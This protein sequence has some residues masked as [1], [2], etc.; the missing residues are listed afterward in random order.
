MIWPVFATVSLLWIGAFA[1]LFLVRWSED[2]APVD[3]T[4]LLREQAC[5]ASYRDPEARDRCL[6]IMELE[7]FQTRSIMVA[8]RVLAGASL[9]LI[10]F[11]VL[12][13]LGRR[14]TGRKGRRT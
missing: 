10:G 3:R 14:R 2:I 8:N 4:Y 5:I 6:L 13:Y 9:P 11:G 7:R 12:V 1:W